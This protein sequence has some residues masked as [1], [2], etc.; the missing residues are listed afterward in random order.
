M[1]HVQMIE[2]VIFMGREYKK[3]MVENF[4]QLENER[5]QRHLIWANIH[6]CGKERLLLLGMNYITEL[7]EGITQQNA[8]G[9]LQKHMP[10]NNSPSC[11]FFI[12]FSLCRMLN[13]MEEDLDTA[14]TN[15]SLVTAKTKELIQRS[16]GKR[17]F[18]II[19]ALTLIVIV[20]LFLILY[21]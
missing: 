21:T 4:T 7:C 11:L 3:V 20:L 13:E 12:L 17:N 8:N 1:W 9:R 10:P 19:V 15:L 2:R 5:K 18:I 14:T 6:D 16:G